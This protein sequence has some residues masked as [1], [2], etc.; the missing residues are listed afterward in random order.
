[1]VSNSNRAQMIVLRSL[2][3]QTAEL[4]LATVDSALEEAR[5]TNQKAMYSETTP[6][7]QINAIISSIIRREQKTAD[8]TQQAHDLLA[9][10][11]Q[12]KEKVME[13]KTE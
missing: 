1:M 5:K 4:G 6:E 7:A 10:V 3:K 8:L 11:E 9:K 13:L 12:E 2:Q